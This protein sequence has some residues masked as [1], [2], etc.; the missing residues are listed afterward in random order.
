MFALF[1]ASFLY[2][3]IV[4]I[5]F[6]K[7]ERYYRTLHFD[8]GLC[9][10]MLKKAL[11]KRINTQKQIF[12]ERFCIIIRVLSDFNLKTNLIKLR[13]LGNKNL[14]INLLHENYFYDVH[15]NN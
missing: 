11:R 7:F 12:I 9:S 2:C 10:K 13:T 15:R 6:N 8:V 3:Y 5:N 1:F 14:I 4:V